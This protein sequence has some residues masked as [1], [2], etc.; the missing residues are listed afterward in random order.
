MNARQ[1]LFQSTPLCITV[2]KKL[3]FLK[4]DFYPSVWTNI[5]NWVIKLC[6]E[7]FEDNQL[8]L[9]RISL[10]T[11]AGKILQFSKKI[12]LNFAIW[13]TKYPNTKNKVLHSGFLQ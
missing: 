5:H 9:K 12:Y 4:F 7:H 10:I 11:S 3:N 6:T 13:S 2:V 1:N 8:K